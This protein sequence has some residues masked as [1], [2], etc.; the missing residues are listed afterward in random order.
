MADMEG[1]S[2]EQLVSGSEIARLAGVTRAAVSNWRRRYEDFPAPKGGG[3]NSPLFAFAEVQAWLD[4]QHK[5]QD[6]SDEVRLWQAVRAAYGEETVAGV[7]DIARRLAQAE[8][9]PDLPVDAV[10]LSGELVRSGSAASVVEGLAARIADFVGRSGSDHVTS[11]RIIRALRHLAG[12]LPA[13]AT[14]L[15]PACGIGTLLLTV[16]P[17]HGLKRFGQEREPHSARLAQLRAD[18][19]G[20]ADV[21]VAEGDS[22]CADQWPQV[23]ADLVVCDPPVGVT[24]WGREAL[25]LD[26]R[27][28]FGTPPKA[29]GELAWLQHAYAHTAPGG[30][31]LMVMP[32]SVA[33]R[34]AGRRIRA[35]LVRRGVLTQVVA[36]PGGVAASH[37]LPVHVWQL[38]RPL[39]AGAEA[40]AV[41]LVDLTANQPD[42]PLDPAPHQVVEASLV[43]LLD[44]A[45]DLT[46]GR[47]IRAPHRDYRAEY[48]SLRAQLE[49]QLA[50]L[51]A[52]LPVL[53]EG[54]GPGTLEAST[55]SVA[56]LTRAGLVEYGDA[57]PVSVSDQ[58]DTDYLRG[59]LHSTA[60]TRRST[61]A[62]GTYR[63]DAR[64]G[65]VPKMEIEAQRR[66]GRAFNAIQEFEE[67][68]REAADL[69]RQAAELARDGLG[70]GALM[71]FP[72]MEA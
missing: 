7:A 11:E 62:S 53:A 44:D 33:Y 9:T 23:R 65:R 70:N 60:N 3:V 8:P 6:V 72:D 37:A 5:G 50:Q 34:K 26:S 35:E 10:R 30:R 18:L 61:S 16:G 71:P 36:L 46:P 17:R 41:R 55:V 15:D 52:L 38:T 29:E 39:E 64:S 69:G 68:V 63:F 4:R 66:Y 2:P 28:E 47:H 42:G 20:Q 57:E 12:A 67:R 54:T 25:L 51:A 58:L 21:S 31:V 19:G 49:D 27:W 13:D 56:E 32:A 1:A 45:V 24:E 59:F 43:D 48:E 40:T 14:V 22:L